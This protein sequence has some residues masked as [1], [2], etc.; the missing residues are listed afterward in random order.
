MSLRARPRRPKN[1]NPHAPVHPGQPAH[2]GSQTWNVK[3]RQP[4]APNNARN[5]QGFGRSASGRLERRNA[6]ATVGAGAA[7][8]PAQS[9]RE[10]RYLRPS[11]GRKLWYSDSGNFPSS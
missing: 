7:G 6:L 3:M 4:R 11:V 1:Y 10:A 8:T 5:G 9:A 2:E